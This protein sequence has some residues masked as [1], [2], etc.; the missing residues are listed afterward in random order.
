MRCVQTVPST[1]AV[2][3]ASYRL[4]AGNAKV[5]GMEFVGVVL[6]AFTLGV[7]THWRLTLNSALSEVQSSCLHAWGE[8]RMLRGQSQF[9][10]RHCTRCGAQQDGD[11]VCGPWRNL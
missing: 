1:Q 2:Q 8:A 7:W 11:G 3:R 10:Y 5:N 4:V 6:L 9:W